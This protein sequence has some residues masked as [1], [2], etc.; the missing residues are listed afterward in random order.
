MF[1]QLVVGNPYTL[2]QLGLI[3][4][5]EAQF[6][7]DPTRGI[8]VELLLT[9]VLAAKEKGISPQIIA[10][11]AV[12]GDAN[13]FNQWLRSELLFHTERPVPLIEG[14]MDRSGTFQ[15]MDETGKEGS[16]QVL[17]PYDIQVRREKPSAQDLIVPL[18]RKLVSEN[19]KIIIFRNARGPAQGCANYLAQ[20][21]GL[22]PASDAL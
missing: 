8:N 15:F 17:K 11:S 22:P 12:I 21:L 5:D 20:D 13:N 18:V 19:E 10:L 6:I 7:T 2:G 16:E 4:I 1:L 3:V 14:G 9:F